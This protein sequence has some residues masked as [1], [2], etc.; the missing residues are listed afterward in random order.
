MGEIE[1]RQH[2]R[3]KIAQGKLPGVVALGPGNVL[4]T[5]VQLVKQNVRHEPTLAERLGIR[6]PQPIDI[7]DLP[8]M[9][10]EDR[11]IPTLKVLPPSPAIP[12]QS[13]PVYNMADILSPPVEVEAHNEPKPQRPNV[14]PLRVPP[15]R[16]K[17]VV[18]EEL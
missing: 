3:D 18:E 7:N 12:K 4:P 17:R 8:K 6:V 15:S 1:N 5:P 11:S 10:T 13:T 16:S 9:A 2:I 14:L